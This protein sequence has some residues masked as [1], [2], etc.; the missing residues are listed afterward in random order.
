MCAKKMNK[1]VV[2]SNWPVFSAS[3]KRSS[4]KQS[5]EVQLSLF[6]SFTWNVM[7]QHDDN[8]QC[9]FWFECSK[10]FFWPSCKTREMERFVFAVRMVLDFKR[11]LLRD[12]NNFVLTLSDTQSNGEY[13][14]RTHQQSDS[15][16]ELLRTFLFGRMHHTLLERWKS[17][18]DGT[19]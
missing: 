10:Q 5:H 8:N 9:L 7:C 4:M 13:W 1:K 19:N 3:H 17:I 11:L 2:S 15:H 18:A 16:I 12:S 14:K 6:W